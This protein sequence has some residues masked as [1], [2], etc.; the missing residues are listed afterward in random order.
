M[1][2]TKSELPRLSEIID[3]YISQGFTSIFL[4]MLNPYGQ[5]ERN[6][7]GI[8]YS[9]EE[10][11]EAYKKALNYIIELNLRGVFFVEEFASILLR[12]V[13]TPFST[14]FVDLQSPAG[15]G[16]GGVIYN[17][18]GNVYASDE[19][20]MLAEMGDKKFLIGNVHSNTYYEIFSGDSLKSLIK[21]SCLE[22]L[23]FCSTCAYQT[24]CGADPVRNYVEQGDIIGNKMKSAVCKKN[25]AIIQCLLELIEGNNPDV[26]DVFW[27]WLTNRPLREIRLTDSV[28]DEKT[29]R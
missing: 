2:A 22:C 15:I 19:G 24:Y 28:R 16:I 18:D 13:L 5:A 23:P 8:G 12:K 17:Y 21:S 29:L 3:E 11:V 1:T 25:R 14:G 10:F 4:R 20:R 27:S 6:K 9:W 7:A 26:M